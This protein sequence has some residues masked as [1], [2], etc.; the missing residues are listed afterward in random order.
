MSL[1]GQVHVDAVGS[2]IIWH[3]QFVIAMVTHLLHDLRN[4]KQETENEV[5]KKPAIVHMMFRKKDTKQTLSQKQ[6]NVL[7]PAKPLW[8]PKGG[9]I[10]NTGADRHSFS[11]DV[12][13]F[14]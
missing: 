4:Q 14:V 3:R 1:V 13:F 7:L 6:G 12:M 10:G 5:N 8:V 11:A 9:L 2:K